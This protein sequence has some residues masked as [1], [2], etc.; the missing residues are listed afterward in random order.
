[1]SISGVQGIQRG[2]V[3]S[4]VQLVLPSLV[5]L[6]LAISI[7]Y[8]NEVESLKQIISID[9]SHTVKLATKSINLE[10][11]GVLSDLQYLKNQP[12]FRQYINNPHS[13]RKSLQQDWLTFSTHRKIYDQIRFIDKDGNE[14]IRVNNDNNIAVVVAD[15]Q[16]QYKGHRHYVSDTLVLNN[17]DIYVSDLTLNIEQQEIEIPY[18]PVIR[19]S[20]PIFNNNNQLQGLLIL[21]YQAHTLLDKLRKLTVNG[22]S[23][24]WL[25]NHDGYWLLS[26]DQLMEWGFLHNQTTVSNFATIY[27]TVWQKMLFGPPTGQIQGP[28][29]TF[30]YQRIDGESSPLGKHAETWILIS[31]LPQKTWSRLTAEKLNNNLFSFILYALILSLIALI[32]ASKNMANRRIQLNLRRSEA[33]FRGLLDAAPDAIII[34]N[35]KGRII[36]SSSHAQ[37]TLGYSKEEL[38]NLPVEHLLPLRLRKQHIK[39]RKSY[40]SRPVVREM[41]GQL[42]LFAVHKNGREIPVEIS[43]SPIQ[44][45]QELLTISILRDVTNRKKIERQKLDA[46][47]RFHSLVDN[48]PIGVFRC[49]FFDSSFTEVNPSVIQILA[50]GNN[51][52]LLGQPFANRF[53]SSSDWRRLEQALH[54]EHKITAMEVELCGLDNQYFAA[55]ISAAVKTDS[56]GIKFIDGTIENISIRKQ[57]DQ[58]IKELNKRL[59]SYTQELEAANNELEAFSYSVS[60][61][62]RAPLRAM[63]GFSQTLLEQYQSRL[64]DKGI[65]RLKRIRSAAGRMAELVESLIDLAKVS[66]ATINRQ[67]VN[68]SSTATD[69]VNELRMQFPGKQ[70]VSVQENL[71]CQTDPALIRIVLNNL[72]GNAWKF[73]AKQ[74]QPVIAFGLSHYIDN[75]AV[76]FVRDNGVGFDMDYAERLFQ[77]FQRLHTVKDYPGTGIG[78]ATVHRIIRKH[79]GKIWAQSQINQGSTFYFTLSQNNHMS[80]DK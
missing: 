64:D 31:A 20:T 37:K 21:N 53:K 32:I 57:K 22:Q 69:V 62:L 28:A 2:F 47:K 27:P 79:G 1:M 76:Y 36:L 73:S 7:F 8:R 19:V 50:A 55:S 12:L 38:N 11:S 44:V 70:Q 35:Q 3:R 17:D 66:R 52:Q 78:L 9:E 67:K 60:H 65:D 71:I 14:A 5:V 46:E 45:E 33:K 74:P 51:T 61:D 43:L 54:D 56:E 25:L 77:P 18:S 40:T 80:S 42:E 15:E 72:L 6:A 59:H 24:F 63:D 68:I 39:H 30:T 34:V 10:L 58:K 13:N 23:E 49:R 4:F 29:Y 75:T 48:L 16:L 41:G 26:D